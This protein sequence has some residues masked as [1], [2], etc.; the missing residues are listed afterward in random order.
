MSDYFVNREVEHPRRV[1]IE[2]VNGGFMSASIDENGVVNFTDGETGFLADLERAEGTVYEEGTALNA[3]NLNEGIA[4][5]IGERV[6]GYILTATHGTPLPVEA[7]VEYVVIWSAQGTAGSRGID[8]VWLED[9]TPVSRNIVLSG[10]QLLSYMPTGT[11]DQWA[12]AN[13]AQS[14]AVHVTVISQSV[15]E[16]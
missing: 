6:R 11:E 5:M 10:T 7:G 2:A 12:I 9:S 15:T 4:G 8:Y 3:Q 14:T 13:T 16:V 1:N